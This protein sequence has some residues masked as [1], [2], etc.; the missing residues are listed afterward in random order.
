MELEKYHYYYSGGLAELVKDPSEIT[1]S[2]FSSW[3][4]G[5]HSLGLA[6]KLLH[7]PCE[8]LSLSLL[9]HK[10][11]TLFVNLKH[12]EATLY[13]KTIFSYAPQKTPDQ[14]PQLIV[15][16]QKIINP[17][18]IIHS[19][20]I[21]WQQS[22]WIAFPDKAIAAAE[23]FVASIPNRHPVS[24]LKDIHTLLQVKVWPYVLSISMLHEFYSQLLQREAKNDISSIHQYISQQL[25]VNDW[26]YLSLADQVLVKEGSLS[27]ETY[28][29]RYGLRADKD[30]ELTCPRWYEIPEEIAS[31]IKHVQKPRINASQHIEIKNT[32]LKTLA[33]QVVQFQKMR[34]EAKHKALIWIDM[35]RQ[36]L[37]QQKQIHITRVSPPLNN[38][39]QTNEQFVSHGKGLPVSQGKATGVA[40]HITTS[41]NLPADTIGIFDSAGTDFSHLYTQCAGLIFLSGGQ[42]SH[43]S[44]VAR[45]YHIPA[46][47]DSKAQYIPER[48]TLAINGATG[49]WKVIT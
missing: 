39:E 20:Q 9:E 24:S 12:E 25:S 41:F 49:E 13:G 2:Y 4:T 38:N 33:D 46:L 27:F 37:I 8:P 40:R 47:I 29:E 14:S 21:L 44:I 10:D 11:N 35:L 43:G 16:F 42:M 3:F 23:T 28:I 26:F 45:E 5:L 19:L 15:N 30:Y 18:H 22:I 31:R 32:R 7:L 36:L 48:S 34:M 6:M 17:I 1:F